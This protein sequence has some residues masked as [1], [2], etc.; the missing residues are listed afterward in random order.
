ML[1]AN[2]ILPSVVSSPPVSLTVFASLTTLTGNDKDVY[3]RINGGS[4]V[5]LSTI[6]STVC[7][8]FGDIFPL[9]AGDVIQFAVEDTVLGNGRD[10]QGLDNS[11]SCSSATT[12]YLDDR[13]DTCFGDHFTVT[14]GA[15][16]KNCAIQIGNTAGCA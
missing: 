16:N 15:A 4:W 7:G 13:A 11:S 14:M 9:Q 5:F 2:Q 12:T 6:T 3:Y 10:Y 1:L 8:D